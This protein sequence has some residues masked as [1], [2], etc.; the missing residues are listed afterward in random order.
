ML[1]LTCLLLAGMRG[2]ASGG[3]VGSAG[4]ER[5]RRR[6]ADYGIVRWEDGVR[7]SAVH[8]GATMTVAL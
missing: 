4:G 8:G 7:T 2:S 3:H 6:G 5:T 1:C